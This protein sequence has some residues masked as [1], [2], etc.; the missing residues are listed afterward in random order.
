MRSSDPELAG[1]FREHLV[2]TEEHERLVRSRL[3]EHDSDPSRLKDL[4]M[5]VGGAGFLLFA[6]AQPDTSGKLVAHA[7]SYEHLE[8]AAYELL[9]RVAERAGDTATAET[10]REDPRP[11]GA[12]GE[13][14]RGR[15]S[16]A[17]PRHRSARSAGTTSTSS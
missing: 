7:Y 2:E 15:T 5:R 10:A 16:T 4:L 13:A 3:E 1:I 12:H 11:G 6:K 17:R 9:R 14:A 8:L